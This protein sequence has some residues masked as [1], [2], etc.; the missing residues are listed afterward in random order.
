MTKRIIMKT[1]Y[2]GAERSVLPDTEAEF[3]D[4]EAEALVKGGYAHYVAG[5]NAP[6]AEKAVLEAEETA[7]A[8]P[9]LTLSS[10]SKGR[11]G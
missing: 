9:T 2:A 7:D 4:A 1:L 3:S 8:R 10:Q 6:I 11:R 5:R